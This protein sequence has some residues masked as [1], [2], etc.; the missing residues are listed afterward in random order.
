MNVNFILLIIF[1]LLMCFIGGQKGRTALVA[2]FLNLLFMFV[3]VLK[4]KS[5]SGLKLLILQGKN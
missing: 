2:L 1:C 4:V 3:K 5:R